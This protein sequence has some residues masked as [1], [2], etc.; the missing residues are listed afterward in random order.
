MKLNEVR[1]SNILIE[2]RTSHFRK[3]LIHKAFLFL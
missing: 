3:A 2:K 1:F